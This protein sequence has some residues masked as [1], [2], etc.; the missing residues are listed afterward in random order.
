MKQKIHTIKQ[1]VIRYER[2]LSSGALFLGFIVDSFT[3]KRID[4][5]FENLIFSGYILIAGLCI[6]ILNVVESRTEKGKVAAQLSLWTPFV[7]QFAFGGLFSG[8]TIFYS[9]SGSLAASWPFILMLV[10][11]L[12][13]NELLKKQYERLVFQITIYFTALF[14]FSIFSIP[15]LVGAMGAG[16]FIVS[17]LV[18]VGLIS[19]FIWLLTRFAR[20]RMKKS[21]NLL[22]AAIGLVFILINTLYFAN[23]IPPIPLSLKNVGVYHSVVRSGAEY[24]VK[25]E[26]HSWV[27]KIKPYETIHTVPG[28]P[29]YTYSAVFAPTKIQTDIVHHWQ[30]FDPINK[31]W[32]TA[33]KISY[34]IT[35]GNDWGYRGYTYK[36]NMA[37]GKWRVDVET[38]RGQ[39]IGRKVFTVEYV[40]AVPELEEKPLKVN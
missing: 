5:P 34:P 24:V 9:R 2:H 38:V 26:K 6:F 12:V 35:G 39:L 36:T 13:G 22:V 27:T 16:I 37:E 21:R 3:L 33:N 1:W 40:D 31:K 14:F 32:V 11:I 23:V 20:P 10:G 7:L 17:G 28:N 30:F 8:F 4:L 18:S 29:I 15:V 19:L 25:Q